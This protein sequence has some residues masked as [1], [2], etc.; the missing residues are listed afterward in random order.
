[1]DDNDN[2]LDVE[3]LF[4]S[5]ISN[6]ALKKLAE[7]EEPRFLSIILRNKECLMDAI[8]FGIKPGAEGH[9][10]ISKPRSLFSIISAYYEKYHT[11]LTRTAIESIMESMDSFN[12]KP[13]SEEEK[14]NVRMYW[15]NVWSVNCPVED[16]ELLRDNIN[17]R[18]VQWQAY[19]ILRERM[20]TVVRSTN[21]QSELIRDIRED[22]YKIDN[23]DADPYA[24]T[25]DINEGIDRSMEVIKDRRDNPDDSPAI[26]TG[27]GA[28]DKM[29]HGFNPGSYTLV[30]GQINGGKTTFMFNVG[31]N[32]AKMGYGVCYVSME[33]EAIAFFTRLLSLHALVDY[34]RIKIGGVKES[35]LNDYYYNKLL[36]AGRQLKEDI[37]PKMTCIQLAQGTK[38]SKVIAEVEKVKARMKIDVLIVDYLGV[39]GAET[40]HPGRPD[41]DEYKVSQRLQAY[42]RINRYVTITA[43]QLKTTSAKDSRGKQKKAT[44]EDQSMIEINTEDISGSKMIPADADNALAVLLNNDKPA[45][46]MFVYSTK[47]RDDESRTVVTLDFDGKIG[48]I[49]DPVLESGQ[50]TE[51]DQIL[52]NSNITEAALSSDDGL[53]DEM[54]K[55]EKTK[56][57]PKKTVIIQDPVTTT[58][59]TPPLVKKEVIKQES[60][61][62]SLPIPNSD[63]D[64]DVFN[65]G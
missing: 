30:S 64:D 45:T 17:D 38:I 58:T 5:R 41:L 48:R 3:S 22:F 33:K 2:I 32:M 27:I 34:N 52:Y 7:K 15:D 40:H 28:V 54:D 26:L 23:I 25:M 1:M 63:N 24:L 56:V 4:D 37:C 16:Y 49:S 35:G 18:Y 46:K 11:L 65:I 50:V 51:V 43:S 62:K 19:K 42:G 61:P 47:A 8:S 12:G 57:A 60:P 29:Y 9:F 21:N 20:D 10:W 36:E 31:F 14:T 59:T 39:I 53:F 55:M 6:E 44:N 13:I